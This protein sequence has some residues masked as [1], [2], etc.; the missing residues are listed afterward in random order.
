[1]KQKYF[2]LARKMSYKSD[3]ADYRLGAVVVKKNKIL[4]VGYNRNKTHTKSPHPYRHL[5]AEIDALLGISHDDLRNAEMY[6]W[7]H[8][9]NG[10]RAMAKPCASCMQAIRV[11]RIRKLYYTIDNGYTEEVV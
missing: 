9:K 11:A 10:E 7:R 4:G 1:M 3:H 8:I 5:H 2:D 6:V